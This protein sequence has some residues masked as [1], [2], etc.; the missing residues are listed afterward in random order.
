MV[1][2]REG[3]QES[4]SR[5]DRYPCPLE[6]R[7]LKKYLPKAF[8][9]LLLACTLS[10]VSSWIL[11]KEGEPAS[12]HFRSMLLMTMGIG[13]IPCAI[14][15]AFDSIVQWSKRTPAF[16][17]L[18]EEMIIKWW[19]QQ[20]KFL[21]GSRAL[22]LASIVFGALT[23]FAE[24]LS[25]NY[26]TSL[27]YVIL[28]LISFTVLA[29]IWCGFGLT[30][31]FKLSLVF[32]RLGRLPIT[33]TA[34]RLG[35]TSAGSIL[36][37]IWLLAGL[38]YTVYTSTAI[39][40]PG[41]IVLGNAA[42]MLLA[43]PAGLVIF[44]GLLMSQINLHKAM[45]RYKERQLQELQIQLRTTK[46]EFLTARSHEAGKRL[47]HLR[48]LHNEVSALPEWPFSWRHVLGFGS[49]TIGSFIPTVLGIWKL[50]D[51]ISKHPVP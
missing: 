19:T 3:E 41:E 31:F 51:Q 29:G 44:G 5:I 33:V 12:G 21:W 40:R 45:L 14:I 48:D 46:E 13:L 18:P 27:I 32:S 23:L 15:H 47:R 4:V 39:L 50:W 25:R 34:D 6:V 7:C 36:A 42:M 28:V 2:F 8:P 11:L 1:V 35:I 24:I 26:S 16:I 9:Y 22:F 37:K 10:F 43:L 17:E 30:L 20:F 38:L 49:Y